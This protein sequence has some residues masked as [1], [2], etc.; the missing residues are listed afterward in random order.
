MILW[1]NRPRVDTE[2]PDRSVGT[3][4]RER[5][6]ERLPRPLTTS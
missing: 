1:R 2:H 3:Q 5:E 6:T 4:V